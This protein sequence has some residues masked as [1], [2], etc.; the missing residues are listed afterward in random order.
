[1]STNLNRIA[2]SVTLTFTCEHC[3]VT[4]EQVVEIP[5]CIRSCGGRAAPV[6]ST[7]IGLTEEQCL[8][9]RAAALRNGPVT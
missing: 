9:L 1:M 5:R 7:S 8:S 3:G 6:A 2:P 4:W